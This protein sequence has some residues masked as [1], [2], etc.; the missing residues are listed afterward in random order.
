MSSSRLVMLSA[1]ETGITDIMKGIA[2]E[3]IGSLAVLCLRVFD[4]W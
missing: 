4:E 1:C 3:F 2:N